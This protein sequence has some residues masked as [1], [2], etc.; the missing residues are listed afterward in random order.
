MHACGVVHVVLI[1]HIHNSGTTYS[2]ENTWTG[3]YTPI[4]VMSFDAT[5]VCVCVCVHVCVRVCVRAYMCVCAC[6]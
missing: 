2:A 3:K 5:P 4:A 6:M 1:S